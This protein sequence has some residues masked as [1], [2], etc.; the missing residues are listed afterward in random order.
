M[1]LRIAL[2]ASLAL[3][4][5]DKPDEAPVA[6]ETTE[7][8][9]VIVAPTEA[10]LDTTLPGADGEQAY[11][12][13]LALEAN[14]GTIIADSTKGA[15]LCFF[16]DEGG[17]ALLTVGAPKIED[18]PGAGV[19]RPNGQ[20]ATALFAQSAGTDYLVNGPTLERK[21][22]DG[23]IAMSVAIVLADDKSSATLTLKTPGSE[24]DSYQG[25]WSCPA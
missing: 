12:E 18:K 19:V 17:R 22:V 24:R 2:L 5:C 14:D 16:T 8:E 6:A 15:G 21:P 23:A 3:A 11:A 4:G 13:L 20:P 1:K 10:K 25:T 7:A 9:N